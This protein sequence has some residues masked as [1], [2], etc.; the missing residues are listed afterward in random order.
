MAT[1]FALRAWYGNHN[2]AVQFDATETGGYGETT[3]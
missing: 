1:L 2:V 3:C